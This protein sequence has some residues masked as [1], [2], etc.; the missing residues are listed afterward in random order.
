MIKLAACADSIADSA[1]T[2]DRVNRPYDAEAG[3]VQYEVWLDDEMRK[4]GLQTGEQEASPSLKRKLEKSADDSGSECGDTFATKEC[5][6]QEFGTALAAE[7]SP[8]WTQ[9]SGRERKGAQPKSTPLSSTESLLLLSLMNSRS[10]SLPAFSEQRT[11]GLVAVC[12]LVHHVLKNEKGVRGTIMDM[13]TKGDAPETESE[14]VALGLLAKVL[15]FKSKK[16]QKVKAAQLRES[17]SS[18]MTRTVEAAVESMVTDQVEQQVQASMKP[19]LLAL[20]K[21]F[22]SAAPTTS[23]PMPS[24]SLP[25]VLN[26]R[27]P[28]Q[29]YGLQFQA[30]DPYGML[31]QLQQQQPHQYQ[32]QY[33]HPP[34]YPP[35]QAGSVFPYPSRLPQPPQLGPLASVARGREQQAVLDE[36]DKLL[37]Q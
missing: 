16:G 31:G 3:M 11:E 23:T 19:L 12:T 17:L 28:D 33:Q 7:L 20:K 21:Y 2:A 8:Y 15:G 27:P 18:L 37:A 26:L 34:P 29:S 6:H 5:S 4:A 24:S 14:D 9:Q 25:Y 22:E 36:L 35:I 13:L 10:K 1:A 30:P 32:Q